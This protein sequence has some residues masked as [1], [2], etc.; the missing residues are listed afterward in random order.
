M[1]AGKN[2]TATPSAEHDPSA[3]FLLWL[4]PTG[5]WTLAA[6]VPDGK[7]TA[8]TYSDA[9]R[10]AAWA[11]ERN[12]AGANLYFVVNRTTDAYLALHLDTDKDGNPPE[13]GHILSMDFAHLDV[14]P[15]A[16][17]D[18]E[19]E[20]VRIFGMLTTGRLP[21]GRQ[22]APPASCLIDS[23]NGG[24]GLWRLSQTLLIEGNA[25]KIAEGEAYNYALENLFGGDRCHNI[26][27]LLRL[28]GLRNWPNATKVKKGYTPTDTELHAY[29]NKDRAFALTDLP[30]PRPKAASSAPAT[31]SRKAP[32]GAAV[33]VGASVGVDELLAWATANGKTI[34]DLPLAV[35]VHGRDFDPVK[36]PSRSEAL[37]AV[38][39]GL[40]RAGVPDEMIVAAIKD[41]NNK[42][43]ACVLDKRNPN[44]EAWGQVNKARVETAR[45]VAEETS[46]TLA[47]MNAQHAVIISGKVRVLSWRRT[48]PKIDRLAPDLQSFEDFRNRY[49]H[50]RV[51]DGTDKQ[52]NTVYKKQGDWWLDHPQRR[53]I[54]GIC[55]A[56]GEP[57]DVDGF[58]N[59]WRGWGVEP[60]PGDWSLMREHV[61]AIL[62]S[63]NDEYTS[64]I[65]RWAAWAV[66]NPDK[67]AESALVFRGRQGTGKGFFGRTLK[68]LFGQ[69]GLHIKSAKHLTG[70][71]NLHLRDCCLL[72]ADEAIAPGDKGAESRLK[73]LITEPDL[74]IEGKGENLVTEPNH[75][76]VVMASNEDWVVPAQADE[77][78]YAV[79]DV[80]S[81]HQ[82]DRAYFE[83]MAD[84]LDNGGRGAMLFDLLA[85]PLGEWHPRW[86]IPQTAALAKQKA[87]GL[88]GFDAFAFDLLVT[89]Q[90]PVERML[91]D[92]RFVTSQDLLDRAQ[93]WLK[94]RPGVNHVTFNKIEGVMA[95]LLGCVKH[96]ISGGSNGYLLRDTGEM[97]RR[98]N[99]ARFA[100]TWDTSSPTVSDADKPPF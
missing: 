49:R 63:G 17:E 5:P 84:Q 82:Q 18:R 20:R 66:Q 2:T 94:G 59:L 80:A 99:A 26:N 67:Q 1:I 64:Y 58:Q 96:R 21:D 7:A 50:H 77:R 69:H 55:F 46:P 85:M 56:P 8:R 68:D 65:L 95:G 37:W 34:P 60:K 88:S 39:C 11:R 73:G 16:G 41:P 47:E 48:H 71:F 15:R 53:Q 6:I 36:Y 38:V 35:L 97:R 28:P 22:A 79:F 52:G 81:D 24:Q 75:L 33:A 29:P 89:D 92:H 76:H 61:R 30:A 4:R 90:W 3:D 51:A 43:S 45:S 27:R 86:N 87:E 12:E 54:L 70:D 62:A 40:A 13:K 83:A 31:A 98:W 72:F 19:A 44:A 100:W 57:A 10:A 23:G 9:G 91:R 42:A 74:T 78:R 32:N 14:D 25:Q 93:H